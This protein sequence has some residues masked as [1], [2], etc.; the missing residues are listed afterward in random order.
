MTNATCNRAAWDR[1]IRAIRECE[2]RAWG[3]GPLADLTRKDLERDPRQCGR[4][5]A[6]QQVREMAENTLFADVQCE[7]EACE[8]VALPIEDQPE[9]GPAAEQER[10][11]DAAEAFRSEAS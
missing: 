2:E 8:P 10:G 11:W 5:D 4:F 6:F 9:D 7:C 3:G 1:L